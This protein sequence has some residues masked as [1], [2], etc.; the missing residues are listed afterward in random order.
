ML[1]LKTRPSKRSIYLFIPCID[2]YMCVWNTLMSRLRRVYC[3]NFSSVVLTAQCGSLKNHLFY[4]FLGK[5]EIINILT[6]NS[7]DLVNERLDL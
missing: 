2:T 5:G 3:I 7:G 1:H 4:F 6:S